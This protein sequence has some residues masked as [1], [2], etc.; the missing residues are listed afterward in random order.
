MSSPPQRQAPIESTGEQTQ[1]QSIPV[2]REELVVDTVCQ[3]MG[4]VRVRKIVHEIAQS[5]P[6]ADF[7]ERVEIERKPVIRMVEATQDIRHESGVMIV[8]V[9]EERLV[10][11]LF[12]IE[13]IHVTRRRQAASVTT[14]ATIPLRQ[15][16]VVIERFDTASQTWMVD[17]AY[18]GTK[19]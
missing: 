13:E 3:H 16:E 17:P 10:K 18:A 7:Q 9:Y 19:A 8:P 2:I 14:D 1:R 6:S 12:L 11:Q 15:E 5:A 4:T